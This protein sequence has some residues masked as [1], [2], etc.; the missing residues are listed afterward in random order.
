MHVCS[1]LWARTAAPSRRCHRRVARTL[2]VQAEKNDQEVIQDLVCTSA[3]M[4]CMALHPHPWGRS[5]PALEVC[6]HAQALA[7]LCVCSPAL[8]FLRCLCT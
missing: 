6:R 8:K 7:R 4:W 1:L 3:Y 5:P 2:S